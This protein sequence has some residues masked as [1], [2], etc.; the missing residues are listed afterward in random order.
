MAFLKNLLGYSNLQDD[1]NK[2]NILKLNLVI[3][4]INKSDLKI[5]NNSVNKLND[6]TKI[7]FDFKENR[8]TIIGEMFSSVFPWKIFDIKNMSNNK[9]YLEIILSIA[10]NGNN[11][12]MIIK[13]YRNEILFLGN[14]SNWDCKITCETKIQSE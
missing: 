9:S 10:E 12:F 13:I 7:N 8:M 5:N 3:H 6:I 14:L 2:S 1:F 4:K 11:V